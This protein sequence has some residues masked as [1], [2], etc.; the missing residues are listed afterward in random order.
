MGVAQAVVEVAPRHGFELPSARMSTRDFFGEE[1]RRGVKAAIQKLEAECSAEVVVSVQPSSGNYRASDYLSG[2]LFGFAVVLVFV[3][4]PTPFDSVVF[5]IELFAVFVFGTFLSAW[6]VP[7][8]RLLTPGKLMHE[9]VRRAAKAKFVDAGMSKT[10]AR[11]GILIYVSLFE[12]EVAL[13]ADTGIGEAHQKE[14][15]QAESSLAAAVKVADRGAFTA[16]LAG[17]GPILGEACPRQHDDLNE[18]PDE[19]EVA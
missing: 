6:L 2:S 1:A 15:L 17:L 14:L 11:T 12:R 4:H 19:P 5:P 7:L 8:R 3:F 13:V 10:R 18:L 16:A 9:N